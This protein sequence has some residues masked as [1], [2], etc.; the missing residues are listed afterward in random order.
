MGMRFCIVGRPADERGYHPT[1]GE[2]IGVGIGGPL[3]DGMQEIKVLLDEQGIDGWY[4]FPEPGVLRARLTALEADPS[5]VERGIHAGV[6]GIHFH[7]RSRTA[8]RRLN[9]ENLARMPKEEQRRAICIAH[10][11]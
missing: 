8:T 7:L 11:E 10:A 9:S 4:F 6:P 5:P 2:P 3:F 1:L